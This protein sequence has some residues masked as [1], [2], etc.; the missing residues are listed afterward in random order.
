MLKEFFLKQ[1]LKKKG[2][3]AEQI[4]PLLEIINKN[5]EL[6]Q[7]IAAEIEEKAKREKKDHNAVA[8]EVMRKYQSDLQK[9][10]KK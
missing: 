8:L 3:P 2:V 4:N 10:L 1:M 6:F 5:P 9:I 7:K